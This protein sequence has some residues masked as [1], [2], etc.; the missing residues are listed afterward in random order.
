LA[1]LLFTHGVQRSL[2][3]AGAFS[4]VNSRATSD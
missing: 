1:A 4:S 2:A 3:P